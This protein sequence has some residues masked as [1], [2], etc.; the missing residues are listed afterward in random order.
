M[1]FVSKTCIHKGIICLQSLKAENLIVVTDNEIN[2]YLKEV[3]LLS[4]NSSIEDKE[5]GIEIF[6][7]DFHS[8]KAA[9]PIKFIVQ[10]GSN[11]ISFKE[12]HS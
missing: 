7:S 10:G 4:A 5:E 11:I 9:F 8:F 2:T 1:I 6:K 12:E 3:E